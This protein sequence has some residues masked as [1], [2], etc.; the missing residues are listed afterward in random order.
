MRDL[1]A[2]FGPLPLN[3]TCSSGRQAALE[4]F[5][6]EQFDF[7]TIAQKHAQKYQLVG[8]RLNFDTFRG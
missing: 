7:L 1:D 6:F 3:R 2:D 4:F 8:L 5:A